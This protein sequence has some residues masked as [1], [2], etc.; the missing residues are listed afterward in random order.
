MTVFLLRNPL[1]LKGILKKKVMKTG[2]VAFMIVLFLQAVRCQ[3]WHPAEGIPDTLWIY[4]LAAYH[5]YIF[6]AT[7]YGIYRSEDWGQTWETSNNGIEP[8]H[9]AARALAGSGDTIFV[10]T[11]NG[12]FRTKDFGNS[13]SSMNLPENTPTLSIFVD[14][15]ILLAGVVGG[16][17]YRSDDYGKTWNGVSGE[18]FYKIAKY[19]QYYFAGSW[20][21]VLLSDDYG[22]TWNSCGL[23]GLTYWM[24]NFQDTIY[25]CPTTGGLAKTSPEIVSWQYEPGL[26]FPLN[27]IT[28]A[29]DT[30]FSISAD[31][32]YFTAQDLTGN[33]WIR[34]PT[35]DMDISGDDFL[36][37]ITVYGGN[38]IVG[39]EN[40]A[41]TGKGVWY[42]PLHPTSVSTTKAIPVQDRILVCPNPAVDQV[43]IEGISD[44]CK[45]EIYCMS[46]NLLMDGIDPRKTI[47]VGHLKPGVYVL[48]I[49]FAEGI[50]IKK[51]AVR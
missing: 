45:A 36:W 14:D 16:G 38:V 30:L 32:V 24:L 40:N 4:D 28:S 21:G 46:G 7:M 12:I 27:G 33:E 31:D 18:H 37:S 22:K 35:N 6:A 19:K 51:F 23:D 47:Y 13:W 11:M 50:V 9:F 3:E 29:G 41:G 10:A 17:L 44:P 20:F 42:Y 48:K 15:S 49:E 1:D 25:A 8:K 26:S 34:I 39:T 43:S 5:N 2:L